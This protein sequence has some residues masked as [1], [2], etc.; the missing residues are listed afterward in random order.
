MASPQAGCR[1]GVRAELWRS[2]SGVMAEVE[3]GCIGAAFPV[4]CY[5]EGFFFV[6]REEAIR[7]GEDAFSIRPIFFCLSYLFC[8]Q[9]FAD[10]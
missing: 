3:H 5:G 7:R 4:S 2:Y 6:V 1:S 10:A 8:C 9:M